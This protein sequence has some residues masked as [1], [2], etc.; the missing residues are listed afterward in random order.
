MKLRPT[1]VPSGALITSILVLFPGRVSAL[2]MTSA[3]AQRTAVN[4]PG[5]SSAFLAQREALQLLGVLEGT[6][7]P[8]PPLGAPDL[9]DEIGGLPAIP[10]PRS[11]ALLDV[12]LRDAGEVNR[13][14]DELR[15]LAIRLSDGALTPLERAGL[16]RIYRR[17]VRELDVLVSRATFAGV[18]LLAGHEIYL[19]LPPPG[20][21]TLRV[22]LPDLTVSTLGVSGPATTLTSAQ[23]AL[24]L[25]DTAIDEV[26]L[27]RA[28]LAVRREELVEGPTPGGLIEVER[29]LVRM[30]ELA[31]MASSGQLS[32]V[33]RTLLDL[34]F[35]SE[36]A[37]IAAA[38]D[39][40]RFGRLDLMVGGTVCLQGAPPG[41]TLFFLEL[42]DIDSVQHGLEGDIL[43]MTSA[44]LALLRIEN[45]LAL[46][47]RERAAVQTARAELE[48]DFLHLR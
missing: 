46:V 18:P 7:R 45:A 30:R 32:T 47:A 42:P 14:L 6:R 48:G 39:V 43:G 27:A 34:S 35:Q 2:A 3:L 4:P 31:V 41:T 28:A 40:T 25:L 15:A 22:E 17:T 16:A 38:V 26:S 20:A 21:E 12:A 33:E 37:R 19:F 8:R 5:R 24:D 29:Q 9:P 10:Y 1:L 13:L 11:R 36:L 23:A 44:E